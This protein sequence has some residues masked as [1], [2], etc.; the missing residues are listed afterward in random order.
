MFAV[1]LIV[2]EYDPAIRFFCDV[3][4]FHLIEDR[5]EGHKR[6]V[7]VAPAAGGFRL[8]LARADNDV[9]RGAIG[10]QGG[11]RVWLFLQCDDFA[12]LHRRMLLAG[13]IFEEAPRR[14]SYGTVAVWR[15]PWGNRWDLLEPHKG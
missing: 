6:W 9:Q 7:T 1:T 4:G 15:D 12:A 13:V 10:N 8:V 3:M 11:G 2:P 5:D 14:E